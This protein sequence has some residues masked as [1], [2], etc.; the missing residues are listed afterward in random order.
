[1]KILVCSCSRSIHIYAQDNETCPFC[2]AALDISEAFDDSIEKSFAFV[3]EKIA[4]ID[5][6]I[7]ASNFRDAL[8]S[9]EEVLE[10][11]PGNSEIWW[12]K[13]LADAKCKSD[14]ELLCAGR[15]LHGNP[16]FEN[17]MEYAWD[18]ETPVYVQIKDVEDLI[19]KLLV[20]SL[21]EQERKEK[22]DTN[23]ERKLT[24]FNQKIHEAG[25]R[26][27][28]AI[29][30]LEGIEKA[31]RETGID[32]SVLA[33]ACQYALRKLH[34]TAEKMKEKHKPEISYPERVEWETQLDVILTMS[35]SKL[36][37]LKKLRSDDNS[38]VAQFIQLERER[39]EIVSRIKQDISQIE[40][41]QHFADDLLASLDRIT[42]EYA[43]VRK[44][45][46][47]GSYEPAKSKL[48]QTHF[49][50]IVD[51]AIR[52]SQGHT[53]AHALLS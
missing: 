4:K 34:E 27:Q 51:K 31:M 33:K 35:N 46:Y 32:F 13:L 44:S 28:E 47:D 43:H 37:R 2:G 30:H 52:A 3:N 53:E 41:I 48:T 12:R 14:M 50:D 22:Y 18:N 7:H 19:V 5:R 42:K 11:I 23:V 10:W 16:A 24:E 8:R 21:D 38:L 6:D 9:I 20:K 29:R 45:V 1:M 39:D 17:A 26:V 15:H 49:N 25:T 40:D 36:E